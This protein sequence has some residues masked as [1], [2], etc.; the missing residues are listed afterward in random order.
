V[1]RGLVAST[2]IALLAQRMVRRICTNC[3]VMNVPTAAQKA[4]FTKEMQQELTAVYK[5]AGC[6]LCGNTGY[7]GRIGIFELLIMG[8]EMQKKLVNNAS[9]GELRE[10]AVHEGYYTMKHDGLLK[11]KEGITTFEEVMSSIFTLG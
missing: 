3:R 7:M 6:H 8:E 5:G 4:I 1:E 9:V 10:Q 11:A 2:L